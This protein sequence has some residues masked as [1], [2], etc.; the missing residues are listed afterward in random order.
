MPVAGVGAGQEMDQHQSSLPL[1]Q[2]AERLFAVDLRVADEVEDVVADLEG[3]TEVE[4]E[5]DHRIE[6]R[7]YPATR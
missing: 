5:L 4:P 7:R 3:R 1:Q 2:V 6:R